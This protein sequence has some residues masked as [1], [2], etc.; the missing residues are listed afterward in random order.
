MRLRRLS[1]VCVLLPFVPYI[2][3][4]YFEWTR[5]VYYTT[6]VGF[7]ASYSLLYNFPALLRAAHVAPI[8]FDDLDDDKAID[9]KIRERF[10]KAF[11]Y[12]LQICTSCIA[13]GLCYYY[14]TFNYKGS[15]L[16][17][18]EVAGVVGGF[19]SLLRS[20]EIGTASVLLACLNYVKNH[21]DG[22]LQK[23]KM[24]FVF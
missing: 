14:Y 17:F 18:F 10:Q 15:Q 7:F 2:Q 9:T 21:E 20:I 8:T 1:L 4:T 5:N 6:V 12:I 16:S 23:I 13:S 22:V 19:V 24:R 11:I 3:T